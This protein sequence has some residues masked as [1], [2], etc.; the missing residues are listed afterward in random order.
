MNSTAYRRIPLAPRDPRCLALAEKRRHSLFAFRRSAD[1]SDAARGVGDHR[2]IGG[3][4]RDRADQSLAFG[5]RRRSGGHKGTQNF[6]DA[7]VQLGQRSEVVQQPEAKCFGGG[8][9]L[10]AQKIAAR[11]ASADRVDDVRRNRRRY[12]SQPRLG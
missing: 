1:A 8:E 10:A 4:L 7:R 2:R 9:A 6:I 11:R 5:L 12:E 3:P